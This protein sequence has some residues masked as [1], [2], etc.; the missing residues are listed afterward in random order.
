MNGVRPGS[1]PDRLAAQFGLA[2]QLGSDPGL[3]PRTRGSLVLCCVRRSVP[4]V[5]PSSSWSRRRGRV[6]RRLHFHLVNGP[7]VPTSPAALLSPCESTPHEESVAVRRAAVRQDPGRR[8]RAGLR[9]R[10]EAPAG[11]DR[12]DCRQPRGADV[13]EHAGRAREERPAARA[14]QPGVQRPHVRQH[15]PHAAEDPAGR[16][17]E[18]RGPRGR[19]LPQCEAVQ[20]GR[21]DLRPARRR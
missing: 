2:A 11:G 13:R 14:R 21:R 4:D 9:G 17:A 1:D 3:T 19:D 10:H 12:G 5:P 6:R 20:A 18:A 15:E 8:L 7:H 16:R